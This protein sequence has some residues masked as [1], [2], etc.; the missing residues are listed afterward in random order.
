MKSRIRL[1]CVTNMRSVWNP[2]SLQKFYNVK[3]YKIVKKMVVAIL[4]VVKL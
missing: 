4:V 3:L 1:K 2:T